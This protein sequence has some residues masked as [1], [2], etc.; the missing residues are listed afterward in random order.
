MTYLTISFFLFL[1]TCNFLHSSHPLFNQS[2]FLPKLRSYPTRC[3]SSRKR[4]SHLN[5]TNQNA[6]FVTTSQSNN[7]RSSWR[8]AKTVL[9]RPWRKPCAPWKRQESQSQYLL[10]QPR[11]STRCPTAGASS[12]W[13]ISKRCLGTCVAVVMNEFETQFLSCFSP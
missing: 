11:G 7:H 10:S 8:P 6:V 3:R 13:S 5:E 2:H 12:Y 4:A 1:S 9:H